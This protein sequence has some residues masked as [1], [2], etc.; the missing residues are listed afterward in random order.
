[1]LTRIGWLQL[2]CTGIGRRQ[3]QEFELQYTYSNNPERSSTY[4]IELKVDSGNE[5]AESN[6]SNNNL[7][8]QLKI[9]PQ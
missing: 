4:S 1:M 9:D 5:V 3:V 7:D 2:D 6:E 8:A